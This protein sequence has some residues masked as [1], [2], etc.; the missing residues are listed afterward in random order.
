MRRYDYSQPS[1]GVIH[2]LSLDGRHKQVM[3]WW[4]DVSRWKGHVI[5]EEHIEVE[6]KAKLGDRPRAMWEV[7]Q[8]LGSGGR[9]LGRWRRKKKSWERK[10]DLTSPGQGK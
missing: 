6:V 5:W 1:M 4:M 7:G 2:T 3:V 8:A 10:K 9:K